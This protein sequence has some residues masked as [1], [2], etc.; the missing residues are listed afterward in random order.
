VRPADLSEWLAALPPQRGL[1]P[2]RREHLV[3]LIRSIAAR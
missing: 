3:E 1:T 2:V